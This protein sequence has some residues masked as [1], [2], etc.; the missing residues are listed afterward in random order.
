[1]GVNKMNKISNNNRQKEILVIKM[2][3]NSKINFSKSMPQ[4]QKLI[5]YKKTKH[6]MIKKAHKMK[7]MKIKL[8]MMIVLVSI[9]KKK[10]KI[11]ITVI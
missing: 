3:K 6:T 2:N 1:M 5:M 4:K 11:A 9:V 10:K 7:K 8:Q